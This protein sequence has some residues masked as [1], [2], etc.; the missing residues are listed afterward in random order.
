VSRVHSR[1]L[2]SA[3]LALAMSITGCAVPFLGQRDGGVKARRA[4][5]ATADATTANAPA[6]VV[7]A[8]VDDAPAWFARARRQLLA[9]SVAAAEQ[10]LRVA[11]EKDA[12][13]SPALALQSK[14][15]FEAGRHADAIERLTIVTAQAERF[16]EAERS[17][18]LAGLALHLDA[19]GQTREARETLASAPGAGERRTSSARV[20]VA[21]RGETPDEATE[22]SRW[23]LDRDPKNAVNLNNRGI[24]L[25]RAGD[26]EAARRTFLEAIERDAKRAGPYYNLAILEK[27][28]LLDDAA[29]ARWY[30]AYRERSQADPDGLADVFRALE[31]KPMAQEGAGR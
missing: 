6:S 25:L 7:A 26:A 31:R 5:K 19:L 13:Y 20:Y 22:L 4:A 15:D 29:A 18:L 16:G 21:L 23:V 28:Y 30:A 11:L 17:M 9:D 14:L 1:L 3:G 24:T 10:S 2:V 12:R 8:E 27:F